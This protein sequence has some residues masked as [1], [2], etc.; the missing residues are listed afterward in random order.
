MKLSQVKTSLKMQY[1]KN[2]EKVT[3]KPNQ[4]AQSSH[5]KLVHT[6]PKKLSNMFVLPLQAARQKLYYLS[7][8]FWSFCSLSPHITWVKLFSCAKTNFFF[9]LRVA[10]VS[11]FSLNM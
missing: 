11:Q 2:Q 10:E 9:S 8:L 1:Y 4:R 3:D 6:L 5:H 7:V